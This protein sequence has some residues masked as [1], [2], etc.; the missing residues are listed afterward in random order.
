MSAESEMRAVIL[1]AAEKLRVIQRADIEDGHYNR[2]YQLPAD[3]AV[4]MA[5]AEGVLRLLASY[6]AVEDAP[7]VNGQPSPQ[8]QG[9][10]VRSSGGQR[11]GSGRF[12][13]ASDEPE[14]DGGSVG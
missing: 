3:C 1:H 2:A 14:P 13:K 7:R 12:I 10:K 5:Y 11:D 4:A 8:R 9:G 6:L